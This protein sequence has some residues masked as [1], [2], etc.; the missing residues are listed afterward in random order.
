MVAHIG[1]HGQCECNAVNSEPG[2]PGPDGERGDAG[3]TGEFGQEGDAG[4]QGAPGEDGAP[5]RTNVISCS[6]LLVHAEPR[7]VPSHVSML[8]CRDMLDSA[9]HLAQRARKGKHA[10]QPKKVQWICCQQLCVYTH[11]AICV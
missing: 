10:W 7:P 9:A 6:V 5:V 3:M 1:D 11:S 2:P 8:S 4:D